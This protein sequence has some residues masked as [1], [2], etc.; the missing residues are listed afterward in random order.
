[1]EMVWKNKPLIRLG[2]SRRYAISPNQ[3][4]FL[5]GLQSQGGPIFWAKCLGLNIGALTTEKA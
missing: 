4:N 1:M 2:G 5:A 3:V